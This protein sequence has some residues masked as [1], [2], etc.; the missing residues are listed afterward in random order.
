MDLLEIS[1]DRPDNPVD[2]VERIATANNWAFERSADDEIT[3]SVEGGWSDYHVSFQW[4]DD[5][6]S[7]HMACAFD[8]KVPPRRRPD[9]LEMLALVNEQ[10]WVGHFDCW[11]QEG[12]IVFRHALL[13]A[14]GAEV[15]SSQ[16][17]A[18][19]RTAVETCERYYQGFQF[20]VWAGKSPREALEAIILETAGEA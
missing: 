1:V 5:I 15:E 18:L 9:M 7:L 11:R 6:E 16:C 14:G 10:L 8:L 12:V 3:I 4:M 13:L 2:L 17:E 19:L 20:L